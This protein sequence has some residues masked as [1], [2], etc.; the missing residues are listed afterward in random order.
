MTLR[1]CAEPARV[2]GQVLDAHGPGVPVLRRF[3]M[4]VTS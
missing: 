4:A 1:G 3:E 2:L